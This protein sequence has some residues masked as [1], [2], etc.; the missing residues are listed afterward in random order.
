[1]DALGITERNI[2]SV[3]WQEE[4]LVK[5]LT[6]NEAVAFF[7]DMLNWVCKND[8]SGNYLGSDMDYFKEEL[9]SLHG[10]WR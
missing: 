8:P 4:H 1:M 10:D 5:D 6:P 7:K 2:D 3:E 9:E